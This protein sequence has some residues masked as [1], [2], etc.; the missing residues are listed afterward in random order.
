MSESFYGS[1]VTQQPF[2][3]CETRTGQL[4]AQIDRRTISSLV[5]CNSHLIL[6]FYCH[7]K[8]GIIAIFSENI[9][10]YIKSE[11][12]AIAAPD[13][14]ISIKFKCPS[15]KFLCKFSPARLR[16]LQWPPCHGQIMNAFPHS[17]C[18]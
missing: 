4:S 1:G 17:T 6:F 13:T 3:C 18:C 10:I 8:V 15:T 12:I 5:A 2:Y 16:P 9:Y 11:R 7:R 14:Q